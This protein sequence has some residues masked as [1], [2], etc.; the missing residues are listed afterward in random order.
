MYNVCLPRV[1]FLC[2][3]RPLEYDHF[4]KKSEVLIVVSVQLIRYAHAIFIMTLSMTLKLLCSNRW[5]LSVK[6]T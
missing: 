2:T 1:A 4:K 5:N 6:T 3:V